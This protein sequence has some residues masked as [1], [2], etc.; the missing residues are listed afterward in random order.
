M[1]GMANIQG[2]LEFAFLSG[3]LQGVV[4]AIGEVEGVISNEGSACS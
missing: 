1:P 3:P 2:G 4:E